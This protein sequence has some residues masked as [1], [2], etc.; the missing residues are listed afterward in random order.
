MSIELNTTSLKQQRYPGISI[1]SPMQEQTPEVRIETERVVFLLGG[2]ERWVI[3][4][5]HFDGT[6]IL[7]VD[8]FTPNRICVELKN[9]FF[10]GTDLPI[11]LTCEVNFGKDSSVMD[12]K[13]EFWE[14]KSQVSLAA[15]LAG[16]QPIREWIEFEE[17]SVCSLGKHGEVFLDGEAK[18]EFF[19][20]WIFRLKGQ[21]IACLHHLGATVHSNQFVFGMATLNHESLFASTPKRRTIFSLQRLRGTTSLAPAIN[22]PE[23]WQVVPPNQTDHLYN[24]LHLETA[25]NQNGS[26]EQAFVAQAD[27]G[28]RGGWALKLHGM[29]DTFPLHN[30]SYAMGFDE[31]TIQAAQFGRF[32]PE[33]LWYHL[34]GCSLLLGDGPDASFELVARDKRIECAVVS[35][36]LLSFAAP[37]QDMVVEAIPTEPFK[38]LG[39]Y[40]A[41]AERHPGFDKTE[42]L[43]LP[44][45]LVDPDLPSPILAM[46]DL[47]FS[48]LRPK[49]LLLLRFA[50]INLVFQTG[51]GKNAH[52]EPVSA[53]KPA[54][55]VVHFS[56]QHIA[57]EAFQEGT[58][59]PEPPVPV[60]MTGPSRLVFRIP[61]TLEE[62][63]Y[64]MEALLNWSS[65]EQSVVPAA[66]SSPVAPNLLLSHITGYNLD[67]ANPLL[68]PE[69]PAQETQAPRVE[70]TAIEAPYRL[71]LS[72]N[73]F[74][75]WGHAAQPVTHGGMTELWH[76]R[77]GVRTKDGVDEQE[78]SL[79][80]VRA[81]W[82]KD[83]DN[84]FTMSLNRKNRA[85]IVTNSSNYLEAIQVNRMMLS[86]L[87]AWLDIEG[88]WQVKPPN[89][90]NNLSNW[91]H[92]AAMGRDNYVKTVHEGY[93][94]PFGHRA[95]MIDVT[96]R[97]FELSPSPDQEMVAYLVSWRI[98]VVREPERIFPVPGM[99]NEGRQ[100]PFRQVR[101]KTLQTPHLDPNSGP[102]LMVDKKDFLFQ[103]V[104]ED[105]EGRLIEFTAPLAYV[106]SISDFPTLIEEFNNMPANATRRTRLMDGQKLAFG[107]T[108]KPGDT[109]FVTNS[110]TFGAVNTAVS[111]GYY[112]VLST[113]DVKIPAT[114]QIAGTDSKNLDSNDK[115]IIVKYDKTYLQSGFDKNP[116][117]VFFEL[118][119][120]VSKTFPGDKAGGIVTPDLTIKGLS[121]TYGPVAENAIKDFLDPEHIL[122]Q[123]KLL[124]GILLKEIVKPVKISESPGSIPQLTSRV[125]YPK[126][127]GI[128]DTN[129]VPK[130]IE[131]LYKLE[132]KMKSHESNIFE[133]NADTSMKLTALIYTK[134][135]TN[136][137]NLESTYDVTGEL[138]N[139]KVNL[140]GTDQTT[141]FLTLHFSQLTFNARSGQKPVVTPKIENVEFGGALQFVT[142]LQSY[143]KSVG[144]DSGIDVTPL[145]VSVSSSMAIPNV[146]LGILALQNL[147]FLTRFN[148]PFDGSPATFYFAFAS[149]ENPFVLTVGTFGGGG[150]F[151]IMLSLDKDNPVKLLEASLE[152]GGNQALDLGVASGGVYLMAGIYYRMENVAPDRRICQLTGYVRCG[153]V[154]QVLGLVTVSAEF[155]LSL[156]YRDPGK[157][158][159]QA[160]LTV[161]IHLL[162]TSKSVDLTVEKQFAGSD[163]DPL[164]EEMINE[165]DWRAY[166]SAFA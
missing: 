103:V 158:W 60:R 156:N 72:P 95:A 6:P 34:S 64:T 5:K 41:G 154:L 23:G 63:P 122:G 96:E 56:P 125:I 2:Q 93:L 84:P 43:G 152:F 114:E 76:T 55:L 160:T 16:E 81:I 33:P 120:P 111:P 22:L 14:I 44:A 147:T 7:T 54:F 140:I 66:V 124:G 94:F 31:S 129:K 105:Q 42:G 24:E 136:D 78:P 12:L 165:N 61:K 58:T 57:E 104:A 157:A 59:Y 98:V 36:A 38:L 131:T 28:D 19:P 151:G 45:L 135:N 109:V 146:T 8:N 82:C 166:C 80:T 162:L 40:P 25:V 86:S 11:N 52:L 75:G 91:M 142:S 92:R 118:D 67:E 117:E 145:G 106:N 62:F 37:L 83:E 73:W 119:V 88:N 123:A 68:V 49:D 127:N 50:F 71:I 130:A 144:D 46:S 20:G 87:G 141:H 128:E 74:A 3:D 102:W 18:M 4:P 70:Y 107:P 112:P 15:W 30:V 48:V 79:R 10:P 13:L 90:S 163:G 27:Q 159:G 89:S 150:F 134:L 155:Y 35:P 132:P 121:R 161:K 17:A 149:R 113:A 26:K 51:G 100:F 138:R 29:P 21:N 47:S 164:I 39:I 133:V 137:N 97:R 139:F 126:V 110:I 116:G 32:S 153:G 101:L 115:Q 65:Y 143:L 85:S 9:A 148:L 77:L 108:S 1:P 53:D 69:L 99:E